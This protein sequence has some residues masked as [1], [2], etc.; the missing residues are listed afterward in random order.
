MSEELHRRSLLISCPVFEREID[1]CIARIGQRVEVQYLSMGLHGDTAKNALIEIQAAV[2]KADPALHNVVL[3][4]YGLCNYG[5]RGLKTRQLPVVL[6][7]VHDCIGLLLGSRK[8][9][10]ELLKY[11]PHTYFQTSGWV[12]MAEEVPA[13][14]L[15]A[16][17]TRTG[18]EYDRETLI[19]KYGAENGDYL[20]EILAKP[21]Y[22]QHLYVATGLPDEES[23]IDRA[24]REACA[25]GCPLRVIRGSTRV[26]ETLLKGPWNDADFLVVPPGK[27]IDLVYDER[28]IT[29]KDCP[30]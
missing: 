25:A 6:P 30:S 2:D 24:R 14:R 4:G 20:C 18:I 7:R 22:H 17:A 5:I 11:Q 23:I 15:N 12:D 10:R 29:F 28:L 3:V 19:A 16:V 8:R 13:R 26:L 21:L 27:Q 1:G 9:Y